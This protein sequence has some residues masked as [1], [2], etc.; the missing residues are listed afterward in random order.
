M[1]NK[2]HY[3]ELLNTNVGK[4]KVL[5]YIGVKNVHSYYLCL[6][7]SCN[8]EYEVIATNLRRKNTHCCRSCS[9]KEMR[10]KFRV[11]LSAVFSRVKKAAKKRNIE[12]SINH[13]FVLNLMEIQNWQCA[14]TKL[15]LFVGYDD[16]GRSSISTA[17]LDRID[18]D[19]GYI[20]RKCTM[21]L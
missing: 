17:S 18:S 12:F 20:E 11:R 15:P 2:D 13:D 1:K 9:G 19:L 10:G 3:N 16:K 6:C 21:G 8:K 14:L 7:T 5:K 4:W